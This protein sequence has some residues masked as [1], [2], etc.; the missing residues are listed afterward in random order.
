[1]A[2]TTP[3][4]WLAGEFVDEGDLNEQIR[5]N[6]NAAFPLGVGAWTSYTPTLTQGATVTKT[7]TYAKYQRIGRTIHF[8]VDL[9]VTGS[10]TG[11]NDI[12]IGLPVAATTS[13]YDIGSGFVYDSSAVAGYAALVEIFATTGF[14][15]RAMTAAAGFLGS[16]TFTAALASGDLL[17]FSGTYEAAS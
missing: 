12:L 11:G 14:K 13:N 2:Y 1:M 3:R 10:G 4:T 6:F 17:R 5:D 9:S 8:A 16:A 7:V 15:L